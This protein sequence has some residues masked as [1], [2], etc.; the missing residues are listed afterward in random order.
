MM[1]SW[2]ILKFSGDLHPKSHKWCSFRKK[3][4]QIK[5]L[6]VNYSDTSAKFQ[7]LSVVLDDSTLLAELNCHANIQDLN[8]SS[9]NATM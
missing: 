6:T 8:M 7:D 2:V 4:F 1:D 5:L 9:V 3:D